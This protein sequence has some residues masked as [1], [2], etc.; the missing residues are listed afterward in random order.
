[1]RIGY[2]YKVSINDK[3][4]IGQTLQHYTK[5]RY[6]HEWAL[7]NNKHYN[8]HLQRAFN[9]YK[10]ID[11][12][13]VEECNEINI[14]DRE[15]YW[16]ELYRS[17]NRKYGFNIESGGNLNK[18]VSEETKKIL[19]EHFKKIRVGEGNP[20]FGRSLS[21]ERKDEIRLMNRGSS[22]KLTEDDV[23]NIK[24][25]LINNV[26]QKEL[27]LKYNVTI[28]TINKIAKCKNWDWVLAELNEELINQSETQKS[29]RDNQI[30]KLNEIGLTNR[31]IAE[32]LGIERATVSLVLKR[33][34][35]ESPVISKLSQDLVNSIVKMFE[36]G[37]KVYE[38]ADNLGI[39][40]STVSRHLKENGLKGRSGGDNSKLSKLKESDVIEIRKLLSE[41]IRVNK[42]AEIFNVKR[43]TISDIKFNRTWKHV[44]HTNSELVKS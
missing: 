17:C 44:I 22:D 27:S 6:D 41:D 11:F 33:N 31:K 30:V 12:E 25:S 37:V 38:I 20:M 2:I 19:S 1:M 34:N 36:S 13:V 35:R 43:Q 23:K 42:I 24:L 15:S 32:E 7:K 8:K 9:K 21:Q 40:K 18:T 28:S 39:S 10:E 16:I 14:D 29:K 5:R 26:E 3:V 4:Y